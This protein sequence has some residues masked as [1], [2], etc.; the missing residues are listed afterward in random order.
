MTKRIKEWKTGCAAFL[1]NAVYRAAEK[2]LQADC[3]GVLLM[4]F[5]DVVLTLVIVVKM[6]PIGS[7]GSLVWAY[8]LLRFAWAASAY[9]ADALMTSVIVAIKR[10]SRP[11]AQLYDRRKWEKTACGMEWEKIQKEKEE[12]EKI[13]RE[14]AEQERMRRERLEREKAE[15]ERAEREKAQ[16]RKQKQT[17]SLQQARQLMRVKESYTRAE[18]KKARN[19]LIKQF[20]PDNTGGGDEEMCKRIN[21]AYNLLLRYAKAE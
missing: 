11:Y 3:Q 21:T 2:K 4:L 16:Q 5:M 9:I 20:H 8:L 18:L 12:Q 1:G 15:R 13:R 19:A 14:R 6:W 17:S 7:F 10:K